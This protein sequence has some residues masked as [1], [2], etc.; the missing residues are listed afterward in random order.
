MEDM[1]IKIQTKQKYETHSD[2]SNDFYKGSIYHR[3]DNTYI[4]YKEKQ[5]S[6]EITNQIKITKDNEVTIRRMGK[7]RT[8]LCFEQDKPYSTFY[9]TA[10]GSLELTF[11]PYKII[12]GGNKHKYNIILEYDIYSQEEKLSSNVYSLLASRCN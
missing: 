4:I 7:A 11:K 8:I 12:C 5:E 1:D 9:N 3:N 2:N 6:E 10:H